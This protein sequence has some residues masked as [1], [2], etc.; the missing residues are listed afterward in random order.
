MSRPKSTRKSSKNAAAKKRLYNGT[1]RFNPTEAHTQE[2][3]QLTPGASTIPG[4]RLLT[5]G[6]KCKPNYRDPVHAIPA[7][8]A[9]KTGI[10]PWDPLMGR[11]QVATGPKFETELRYK[12]E[13]RWGSPLELSWYAMRITLYIINYVE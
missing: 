11:Y 7:L 12:L 4:G 1:V 13:E 2:T 10:S 9:S 3:F 8:D 6:P 5:C